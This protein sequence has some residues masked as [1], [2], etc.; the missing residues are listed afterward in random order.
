MTVKKG[1][2]VSV[3]LWLFYQYVNTIVNFPAFVRM[4]K[5]SVTCTATV[6]QLTQGHFR[7]TNTFSLGS[8]FCYCA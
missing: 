1:M 7:R 3:L 6:L 8:E 4:S 2:Y 5:V